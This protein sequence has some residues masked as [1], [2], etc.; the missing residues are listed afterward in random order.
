MRACPLLLACLAT[1]APSGASQLALTPL[2]RDSITP[3]L[4]FQG[5]GYGIVHVGF[6]SS[7]DVAWEALL[8]FDV[9]SAVPPGSQVSAVTLVLDEFFEI[10]LADTPIELRACTTPWLAGS[11]TWNSPW[12][13][14]GGDFGPSLALAHPFAPGP[15]VFS[16]NAA[17]VAEVQQW[18]DQPLANHGLFLRDPTF[19]VQEVRYSVATLVV[20]FDPPCPAPVSYCVAAPNSLGAGA[21]IDFT[22]SPQISDANFALV[23]SGVRPGAT[24]W[25]FAGALQQQLPLGDG[26]LCTGG[27]LLRF[28]PTLT[29]GANGEFVRA[30]D[31]KAGAGALLTP[32]TA[33]NFQVKYRNVVPG[34]AG[35]NFSNAL[36]VTFCP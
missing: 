8:H 33:W 22:G 20:E 10:G 31:F 6:D 30:L 11:A 26:F 24:G 36:S 32:G 28:N 4:P 5:F 16:S 2:A 7:L 19:S 18:V 3:A 25:L 17:L 21:T 34:G 14:P 27:A 9:A 29:A 12:T 13:T 35:Y 1:A 23:V 15:T